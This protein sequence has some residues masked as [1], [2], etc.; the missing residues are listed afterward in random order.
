MQ[1]FRDMKSRIFYIN[2]AAEG[3]NVCRGVG[4]FRDEKVCA[5]MCF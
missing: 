1:Q 5:G 4:W 3:E 2:F